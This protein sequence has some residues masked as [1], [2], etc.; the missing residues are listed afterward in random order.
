MIR[1]ITVDEPSLALSLLYALVAGGWHTYRAI[2]RGPPL[3]G[4]LVSHHAVIVDAVMIRLMSHRWHSA[5][6]SLVSSRSARVARE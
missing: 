4:P 5:S 2:K 1:L 6:G 3:G